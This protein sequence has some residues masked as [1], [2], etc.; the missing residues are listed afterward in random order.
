LPVSK[1]GG[2]I[3]SRVEALCAPV[4]AENHL[5]LWDV[6]Y[7][8]EGGAWFLRI[9]ID[10]EGGIGLEDCESFTHAINPL[11]DEADP[12]EG[13]YY[14]EV[15][16]PG[17]ERH[18]RK[19]SHFTASIGK[20]VMVRM[21]RPL[22]DG[23]RELEGVLTAFEQGTVTI[24]ADQGEERLQIDQTAFIRLMDESNNRG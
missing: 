2:I 4:A 6:V 7:E 21:I 8:K 23:R 9:L 13:N 10:K 1:G 11:I 5:S 15:S 18:L 16:S 12:I 14:L 17:I 3:A 19:I 22:E 20:R 24:S